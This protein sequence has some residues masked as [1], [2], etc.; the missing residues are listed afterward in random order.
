[1]RRQNF[2]QT[3]HMHVR[4][5]ISLYLFTLVLFTMGVCFGA[6]VVN[7]LELTQKQDLMGYLGQFFLEFKQGIELNPKAAFQQSFMQ[8]LKFVGLMWVLGM[9]IVGLPIILILVFLKGLVVGFTVGFLVHQWHWNGL[10]IAGVSVLPQN[11]LVIPAIIVVGTA[12]IS[13]SLRLIRSRFKRPGEPIFQ[14]FMKYSFL[15]LLMGGLLCSA[16]L[17]QAFVSP[18][19]M[20]QLTLQLMLPLK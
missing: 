19:L 17:F 18:L 10:L 9:S 16:A 5:N 2:G 3:I 8:Y 14:H 1:V 15:V 4:E 11:L 6:V 13:F 12:G 20:K 7:S